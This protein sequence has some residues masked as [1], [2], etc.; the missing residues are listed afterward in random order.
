MKKLLVSFC[1]VALGLAAGLTVPRIFAQ[2]DSQQGV[3]KWEQFCEVA[4][5]SAAKRFAKDVEEWNA[6]LKAHGAK[7][8][9][10]VG[11]AGSGSAVSLC[12]RRPAR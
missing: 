2:S 8:Y 5:F 1:L 11:Q 6:S 7:G 12:Y 3:Q 9:E 4:A 10:L